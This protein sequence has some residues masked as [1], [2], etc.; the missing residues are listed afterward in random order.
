[1]GFPSKD[2]AEFLIYYQDNLKLYFRRFQ[3]YYVIK[4]VQPK[5]RSNLEY[6]TLGQRQIWTSLGQ[7]P[8]GHP[9]FNLSFTRT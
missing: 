9:W 8:F 3:Q 4:D 1:M 2:I 7:I 5:L 6:N